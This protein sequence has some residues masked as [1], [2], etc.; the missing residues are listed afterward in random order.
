[1]C[2][3]FMY[4]YIINLKKLNIKFNKNFNRIIINIKNKQNL[5]P[6]LNMYQIKGANFPGSHDPKFCALIIERSK[7]YLKP[8]F[9][10]GNK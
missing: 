5:Q 7:H 2:C 10:M 8:V 1:M 3:H 9:Y 6:K 4:N